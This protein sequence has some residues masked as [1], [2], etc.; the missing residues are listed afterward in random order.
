MR[1]PEPLDLAS[2]DEVAAAF[3]TAHVAGRR[4]VLA[5]SGTSSAPRRIVRTTSSWVDSFAAVSRLSGIDATSRVWVPGPRSAT[6]TLF[7]LVHAAAVGAQVVADLAPATHAHLTPARLAALVASRPADLAG[8]TVITAG[9]RLERRAHDAATAVGATVHH[10]FGAAEFSFVAWGSH[11]ED[12]RVFPG[13]EVE[14]RDGEIWVRSPFLAQ[15]PAPGEPTAV[16]MDAAGWRTVGDRG[17]LVGDHLTVT[18]RS[19]AI[20]TAG[21]TVLVADIEHELRAACVGPLVIVG[22]PHPDLGHVIA[23]VV[24]SE[25]DREAAQ[26]RAREALPATHRPR[27]WVVRES[28][29]LT[30]HGKVDRAAVEAAVRMRY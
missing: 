15:A 22:V 29:P 20:T 16:R 27:R 25:A 10:Y 6:M 26:A 14:V 12:L 24:T 4:L 11:A 2:A 3:E 17:T 13:V 7:A 30:P 18:G 21:A 28:L 23:A 9:D 1:P 5:T 8:V 19:G